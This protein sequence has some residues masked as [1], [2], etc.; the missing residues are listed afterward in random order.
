MIIGMNLLKWLEK[1]YESNCDGDW[2]H[3][4]GVKIETLD[5]PG[6]HL[7]L[8]VAETMYEDVIFNDV[9]VERA[10][11]DWVHCRKKEGCI[12]CAGGPGNLGEILEII[13]AWMEK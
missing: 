13:K 12:E 11:S 8:D 2:E 6:W 5:N 3:A 1:W 4:F 10:D 9:I 7:Q